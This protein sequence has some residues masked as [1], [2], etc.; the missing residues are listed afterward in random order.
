[1]KLTLSWALGLFCTAVPAHHA[2]I[3][4]RSGSGLS[5]SLT[6][7]VQRP[8]L[9]MLFALSMLSISCSKLSN[10]M[11]LFSRDMSGDWMAVID[12]FMRSASEGPPIKD[13]RASAL[14]GRV[15]GSSALGSAFAEVLSREASVFS[16][17]HLRSWFRPESIVSMLTFDLKF[18]KNRR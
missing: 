11:S 13:L 12:S 8:R 6:S 1:M 10:A 2:A 7:G 18:K 9:C 14:M 16:I 4:L 3:R 5:S 15:E 17:L